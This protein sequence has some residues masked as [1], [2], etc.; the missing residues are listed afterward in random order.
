MIACTPNLL[1]C[2]EGLNGH[3]YWDEIGK[4]VSQHPRPQAIGRAL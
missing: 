1:E 2:I 4:G 3:Q